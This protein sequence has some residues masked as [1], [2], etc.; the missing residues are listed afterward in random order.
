MLLRRTTTAISY[1]D[2][3]CWEGRFWSM[4][5][6]ISNSC[7]ALVRRSPLFN[8][9]QPASGTVDTSWPVIS[10]ARRRSIHSLINILGTF[11]KP[12]LG[13]FEKS[14]YLSFGYRWKS[15]QKIRNRLLSFEVLN[16]R[17]QRNTR[18]AKNRRSTQDTWIRSNDIGSHNY[19]FTGK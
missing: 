9:A 10:L 19:E 17:L 6:K 2:R 18:T 15:F 11:Q 16:E 12:F 7:W 14:D 8:P 4:V 3:F 13:L 5:M 1:L